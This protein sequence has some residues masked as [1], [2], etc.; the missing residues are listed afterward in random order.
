MID[1]EYV[2]AGVVTKGK[3]KV[4]DQ[5]SFNTALA[6]FPDGLVSVTIATTTEKAQRSLQ[7]NKYMWVL[8]TMIAEETGHTKDEAHDL[9]CAKF[10]SYQLD[11]VDRQTGEVTSV[12]VSRGTSR[13]TSKEHAAFLDQVIQ[14]MGEFLGMTVPE[15]VA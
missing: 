5:R 7:S 6:R 9:L 1:A 12:Q 4:Q 8:F 2:T 3:L 10:L 14:W 15:M 11:T 13:L